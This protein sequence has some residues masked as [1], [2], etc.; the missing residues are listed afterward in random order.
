MRAFLLS[1][2]SLSSLSLGA[3]QLRFQCS[4]ATK[5]GFPELGASGMP[6]LSLISIEG[7]HLPAQLARNHAK[8]KVV[9]GGP[10][11]YHGLLE[12]G[13]LPQ[14]FPNKR[15]Q[16]Y[17]WSHQAAWDTIWLWLGHMLPP[18]VLSKD[19]R[20]SHITSWPRILAKY[21]VSILPL[22]CFVA[23]QTQ[24]FQNGQWVDSNW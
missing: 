22:F 1:L 24:F 7:P 18:Q 5:A 10:S 2:S 15:H 19:S 21:I 6:A 4:L 3:F 13:K 9:W 14:K 11:I 20:P 17:L 16:Y 23:L 12:S 8:G